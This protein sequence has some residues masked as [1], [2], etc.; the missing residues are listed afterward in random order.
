MKYLILVSLIIKSIWCQ[1]NW[2]AGD[3]AEW[4]FSCDFD[5]NDMGNAQMRGEDCGGKCISSP[6]C[7]HF[8]WTNWNGG[9]CWLKSGSVS[10]SNAKYT[11]DNSMVCGITTR[12]GGNPSNFI[13]SL[14]SFFF[15]TF[16]SYYDFYY[17]EELIFD[18]LLFEFFDKKV[19]KK[20]KL[21][22]IKSQK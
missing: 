21:E 19:K 6:G 16:F 15:I 14:N 8:T 5:G 3:G 13:Y 7:T 18:F 11:G 20:A 17:Q 2:Q 1:V 12:N 4:A 10:K 22:I 9:T